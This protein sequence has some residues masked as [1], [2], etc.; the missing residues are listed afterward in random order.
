MIATGEFDN[1]ALTS[2]QFRR[3]VLAGLSQEEKILPCKY[4][5]DEEGARLFEAICE[6]PEYYPTRIESEI[7]RRNMGEIVEL[8]G[9]RCRLVDLGSG[10]GRKTRLL[11]DNLARPASYAP[12]DVAAAQLADSSARLAC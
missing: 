9:P 3:D 5:Y 10:G 11:L 8:L 4:L 1:A 6:L 7:L 12:V 2:E